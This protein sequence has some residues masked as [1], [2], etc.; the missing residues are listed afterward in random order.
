MYG[1]K[2]LFIT[3]FS[4]W[5]NYFILSYQEIYNVL[6]L[7]TKNNTTVDRRKES[8]DFDSYIIFL[9]FEIYYNEIL[10]SFWKLCYTHW[11][12]QQKRSNFCLFDIIQFQI[13]II[14]F[15]N[16]CNFLNNYLSLF[17]YWFLY[18]SSGDKKNLSLFV[19]IYYN[20]VLP[21][22]FQTIP[23]KITVFLRFILNK[24]FLNCI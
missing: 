24:I 10:V 8:N 18:F 1:P 17:L 11:G 5:W 15:V 6:K 22:L 3:D 19:F 9:I 7:D 16:F 12:C 13:H 23:I 2:Y 14:F 4:L 21:F 20:C